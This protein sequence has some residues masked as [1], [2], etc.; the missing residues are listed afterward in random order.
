MR[1][2]Y[3]FVNAERP[4]PYLN[5]LVYCVL[6]RDVRRIVFIHIKGLTDVANASK[7]PDGLS[8]RVMGTVQAQL[9]SRN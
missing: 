1:S 4:D 8:G 3:I 6:R 5:S 2:L 9:V 7:S